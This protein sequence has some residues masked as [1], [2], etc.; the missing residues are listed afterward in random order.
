MYPED[1]L[2]SFGR[3]IQRLL[4][5]DNLTFNECFD[6]FCAILADEQPEIHQGAFLAALAAKGETI[7]EISAVREAILVKD[8]HM[9]EERPAEMLVE[10]SGTGMDSLKT[11][12]IS[13]AAAIIAASAGVPM[14][15]HGARALTSKCGTVDIMDTLGLNVEASV[16]EVGL[17]IRNAGI[18]LFNGMSS[19]VHPGGLFRVLSRMRFG[20][21][22]NV[23]ASL[24]SPV[25]PTHMLRGVYS[26]ES[27]SKARDVIK[28]I[29]VTRALVVHGYDDSGELSM[30]ELSNLGQTDI[31]ELYPDGRENRYTFTPEDVGIK[32]AAF[33]SIASSGD[34]HDEAVRFLKLLAGEGDPAREDIACLNAAAVLY[35]AGKSP[36]LAKGMEKARELVESGA[37]FDRLECWIHAQADSEKIGIKR[38]EGLCREADA[39]QGT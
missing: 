16:E 14:A 8:T 29:G 2:K 22:L 18:G 7:E 20:S 35:L 37:A 6:A 3:L 19:K 25:R 23:A 38:F 24:A 28:T 4:A 36:D 30:D 5:G 32:R 10:N 33:A 13:T 21:V 9:L 11:F 39:H 17:S 26:P 27:A 15:R 12:N 34:R 1:S 31:W